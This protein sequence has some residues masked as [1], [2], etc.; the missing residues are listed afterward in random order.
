M[1]K[2]IGVTGFLFMVIF[3]SSQ[4]VI[5]LEENTPQLYNGLEYGYYIGN[6]Q[7]KEV[8]GE[9]YERYEVI[10]Y[11]NNKN[12]CIKFIPFK[13]TSSGNSN[14]D[15]IAI[16]EFT[17]KNATGKRLTAKG[18]KVAAKPWFTE[19]RV[20]NE[21]SGANQP[22]YKTVNAQIGYAVKSGQSLSNK[23]IVIVPKGERPKL[24]CRT[25]YFPDL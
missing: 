9:P 17:C 19:V 5:E 7:S 18:G 6:E 20:Q 8:K 14:S 10:L 11:V 24:M 4:Q 2:I 25:S 15:E 1:K 21:N 13:I 3:G 23:I 16:A 12:G 22:K